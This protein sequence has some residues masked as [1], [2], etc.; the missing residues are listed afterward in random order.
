MRFSYKSW[1]IV[2]LCSILTITACNRIEKSE[3]DIP[4]TESPSNEEQERPTDNPED[5]ISENKEKR[6]YSSALTQE[7][8][9]E[10]EE[11]AREFYKTSYQFQYYQLN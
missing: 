1:I 7:E 4:P 3:A 6:T 11:L 5:I 9:E 8:I 10:V 2:V